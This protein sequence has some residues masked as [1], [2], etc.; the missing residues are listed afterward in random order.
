MSYN[1]NTLQS[2]PF[3]LELSDDRKATCQPQYHLCST[4][5]IPSR[6]VNHTCRDI[7]GR[8]IIFNQNYIQD[9]FNIYT[10]KIQDYFNIYTQI[11]YLPVTHP[12]R[13]FRLH[14]I[15]SPIAR[16]MVF[17]TGTTH[18]FPVH[19]MAPPI[20]V[21]GKNFLLSPL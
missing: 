20:I 9:Y 16:P 13:R 17:I 11:K 10:N 3:I 8:M 6:S 2:W 4:I 19:Q 14:Q 12:A 18:I 5:S 15:I 21:K 7:G 1:Y